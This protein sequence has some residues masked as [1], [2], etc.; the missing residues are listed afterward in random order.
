MTTKVLAVFVDEYMKDLEFFTTGNVYTM[1]RR[2]SGCLM[3]TD[4]GGCD[5]CVSYMQEGKYAIF[6][7][8]RLAT[9]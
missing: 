1:F 6:G 3:L 2:D 4:E 8:H 5:W 7:T 9:F